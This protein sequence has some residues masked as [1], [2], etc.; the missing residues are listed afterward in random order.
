MRQ[1]KPRMPIWLWMRLIGRVLHSGDNSP[2]GLGYVWCDTSCEST[3]AIWQGGLVEPSSDLD[4]EWPIL[5]L[6]CTDSYWYGGYRPSLALDLAGNPRIG[7]VAQHLVQYGSS[8]TV[9]EDYRAV[10]F[11]FFNQP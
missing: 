2:D 8:C 1:G 10:R 11:I 3:S 4:V 5:P 9:H 7:Y 6:D